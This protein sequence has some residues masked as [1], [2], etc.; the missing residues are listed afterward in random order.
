MGFTLLS[1]ADY[2]SLFQRQSCEEHEDNISLNEVVYLYS[3]CDKS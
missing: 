2:I 1:A 3:G